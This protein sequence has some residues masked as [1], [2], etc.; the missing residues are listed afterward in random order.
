M[1][2]KYALSQRRP[3]YI[4]RDPKAALLIEKKR[5]KLHSIAIPPHTRIQQRKQSRKSWVH[6]LIL[7]H[8][9]PVAKRGQHSQS[10]HARQRKHAQATGP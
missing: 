2:W 5:L 3:S 9:R 7:L 6:G 4:C 8:T 1:S 10:N